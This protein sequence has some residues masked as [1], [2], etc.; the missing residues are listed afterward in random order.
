MNEILASDAPIAGQMHQRYGG[1]MQ[2]QPL[3]A[4]EQEYDNTCRAIDYAEAQIT[5]KPLSLF[6]AGEFMFFNNLV[7]KGWY[8]LAQGQLNRVLVQLG[9]LLKALEE[10]EA[11]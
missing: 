5:A 1:L 10:R 2:S 3:T 6:T 8:F 7:G 11:K 9:K 4:E